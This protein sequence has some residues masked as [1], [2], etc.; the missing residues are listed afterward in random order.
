MTI[1]PPER[2]AYEIQARA[3]HG[4]DLAPAVY[5]ALERYFSL[6]AQARKELRE[7]FTPDE[8][9]LICE[10]LPRIASNTRVPAV[11]ALYDAMADG[12]LC[13]KWGVDE[14]PFVGKLHDLS[15]VE[16]VALTDAVERWQ[17]RMKNDPAPDPE[18][19]L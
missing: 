3:E 16:H 18:T 6:L 17:K 11:L 19:F 15:V 4:R 7:K 10:A 5:R 1:R 14:I 2:L 8:K 13:K 12:R 9:N